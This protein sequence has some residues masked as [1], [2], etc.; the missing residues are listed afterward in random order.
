[1][2]DKPI[3]QTTRSAAVSRKLFLNGFGAVMLSLLS[4][5]LWWTGGHWL[6]AVIFCIMA[7]LAVLVI[8]TILRSRHPL[9]IFEDRIVLSS[10][11]RTNV[12]LANITGIGTHPKRREPSLTYLDEEQGHRGELAIHWRFIKEPQVDVIRQ[13]EDALDRRSA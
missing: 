13:I 8:V 10:G 4:G 9:Q 2:T 12:P 3:Y 1:M 5:W 6:Q 7:P 11:L